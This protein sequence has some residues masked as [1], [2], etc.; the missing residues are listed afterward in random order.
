MLALLDGTSGLGARRIDHADEPE[1]SHVGLGVFASGVLLARYREHTK[2]FAGHLLTEPWEVQTGTGGPYRVFTPFWRAIAGRE[3][4]GLIPP[5]GRLMAP[6]VWP[7]SEALS[8]WNLA[9]GMR[10]GAAITGRV[11]GGRLQLD[12]EIARP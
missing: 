4:M 5:P 10:R 1:E 12:V 8:D 3:P 7:R 6:S 11:A 9:A 2:S